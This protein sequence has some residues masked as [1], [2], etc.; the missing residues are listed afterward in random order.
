VLISKQ[1]DQQMIH[2]QAGLLISEAF[3]ISEGDRDPI[4][5]GIQEIVFALVVLIADP[6]IF[7]LLDKMIPSLSFVDNGLVERMV[8]VLDV[9]SMDVS[10]DRNRAFVLAHRRQFR[11]DGAPFATIEGGWPQAL[12]PV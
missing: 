8:R 11:F 4:T 6:E 2:R 12:S 5:E 7:D 1:K 3:L 9:P 10:G